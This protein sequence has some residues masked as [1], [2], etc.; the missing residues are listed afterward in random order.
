MSR[1]G[2][3]P[4]FRWLGHL[5]AHL[6]L[7]VSVLVGLLVGLLLPGTLD[8]VTRGLLGWNVAVWL[9]LAQVARVMLHA[10]HDRLRQIARAQAES[11]ATVIGIVVV[12]AAVSL[13]GIVAELSAAR[14][15]GAPHA[16]P[17]VALA[18]LTVAGSWLLLPTMFT[19]AYASRYFH[20]SPVEGLKFP[21]AAP[22]Y[23]PGYSDFLYVSFTIA[24]ASQTADVAV[25]TRAMRRLVLLQSV[26]SF[27]F[28]TAILALTVNV[29][30]S[31][32]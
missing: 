2:S 7:I 15:P 23:Q 20:G 30:A 4:R 18:L 5:R 10:D 25:A 28:N 19:L 17:R 9:Y 27:A 26:L 22:D 13:V 14:V 32:F 8:I 21:G 3:L 12:A 31:M 24:V 11:A 1:A 29:A 6:R 16:L